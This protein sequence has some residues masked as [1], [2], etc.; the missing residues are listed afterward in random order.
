MLGRSLSPHAPVIASGK[1]E[2]DVTEKTAIRIAHLVQAEFH[3][4]DDT[5]DYIEC[6]EY[7]TVPEIAAVILK[8]AN[9]SNGPRR[10]IEVKPS[11]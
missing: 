9:R 3:V 7:T 1:Q 2:S 5:G 6:E 8:A 11:N 4:L 10:G